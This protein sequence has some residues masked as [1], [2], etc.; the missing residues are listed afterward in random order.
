MLRLV[1]PLAIVAIALVAAATAG[2]AM[3]TLTGESGP[4]FTCDVHAASG[5]KGAFRV[6]H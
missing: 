3:P 6:T 1:I 4:G 5:M 2:A